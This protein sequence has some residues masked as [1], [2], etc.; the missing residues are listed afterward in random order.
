MQNKVWLGIFVWNLCLLINL[1]YLLFDKILI[2]ELYSIPYEFKTLFMF[3]LFVVIFFFFCLVFCFILYSI[4]YKSVFIQF[5]WQFLSTNSGFWMA[6]ILLRKFDTSFSSSSK[7]KKIKK[8]IKKIY[9][10]KHIQSIWVDNFCV[11]CLVSR[12]NLVLSI[13]IWCFRVLWT[14]SI[15]SN[16]IMVH[17]LNLVEVGRVQTISYTKLYRNTEH[18]EVLNQYSLTPAQV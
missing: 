16:I 13:M 7:K 10:I 15:F 18:L 3:L 11:S 5:S 2:F 12:T 8:I 1:K 17:L 6:N 9:F 14:F 4:N